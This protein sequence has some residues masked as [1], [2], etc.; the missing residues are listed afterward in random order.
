LS[1]SLSRSAPKKQDIE[2]LPGEFGEIPGRETGHVKI[3][4]EFS[5]GA[6]ER[7]DMNYS[8]PLFWYSEY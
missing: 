5:E 6:E 1:S 2:C 7:Q 4:S 8:Y 3:M